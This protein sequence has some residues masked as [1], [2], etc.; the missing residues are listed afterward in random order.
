MRKLLTYD[1]SPPV[2]GEDRSYR[3]THPESGHVTFASDYWTWKQKILEYRKDNGLSI[4]GVMERAEDQLCG[5]LPPDRCSYE[6]GDPAPI[7]VNFGVGKVREWVTSVINL[8]TGPEGFVDQETA[9]TRATTCVRC[10][11]NVQVEGGC[12]G[13]CQKLVEMFTPGMLKR[14]TRQDERLKSCAVC[15]CFNRVSVH[16]PLTVL[17][18]SANVGADWPDWCWHKP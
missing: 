1:V 15:G 12:G 11:Y 14:K 6:A 13:G 5:T 2:D 16:F 3:Y 8:I 4:D 17:E 7:S 18:K 9:E 10:P